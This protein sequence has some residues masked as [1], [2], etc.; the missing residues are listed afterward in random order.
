LETLLRRDGSAV[1]MVVYQC[2]QAIDMYGLET[3][4]I[5]RLSGTATHVAKIKAMFDNGKFLRYI[6][7]PANTNLAFRL[8]PSRLPKPRAILPRCEQRCWRLKTVL[9]GSS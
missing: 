8:F 2:V 1:P 5:Y 7:L 4:G 3:E 6:E 9:Q